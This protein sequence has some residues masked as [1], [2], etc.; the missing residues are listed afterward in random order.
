VCLY[1]VYEVG[2][3]RRLKL[4][5]V[6]CAVYLSTAE[7][8]DGVAVARLTV[9]GAAFDELVDSLLHLRLSSTDYVGLEVDEFAECAADVEAE[10]NGGVELGPVQLEVALMLQGGAA[11]AVALPG[12]PA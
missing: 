11:G 2:H 5:E 3:H 7:L 4:E 10:A 9:R 12:E 1:D 6:E 8:Q